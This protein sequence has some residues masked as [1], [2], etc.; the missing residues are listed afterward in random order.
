M[1]LYANFIG[2]DIAKLTFVISLYGAKTTREYENSSVGIAKFI[3]EHTHILKDSLCLLETTGG[4][5]LPLLYTLVDLGYSVHRANARKVKH[6]IK[7]FGNI[8]KTDVLDA[9]A[10]GTYAHER[11]DK[12]ELFK[13]HSKEDIRLFQLVQRRRD[14]NQMLISEKNRLQTPSISTVKSSVEQMINILKGELEQ[15]T[16]AIQS[17]ID[18]NE[19]LK[20]KQKVLKSVPGIGNIV[21]FELLIL[22]PELGTLCRRK[23]ASLAGLA[24]RANE[25]GKF[26]GYRRTSHGRVGVKRILFMAAMAARNSNSTLKIF[27]QRLIESGKKK[28][29]ALT[30]LMRKI[31]VI[32]NARLKSTL[33]A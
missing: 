25:S 18:S 8:A 33:Y 23:V 5:E 32:A 15:I 12:L 20:E 26:V 10:L 3:E 16:Q 14:I 2:I 29:V 6:F 1:S 7:S 22:L 11:K 31:L 21:A 4:Y 28:M 19:V 24:P 17:I 27:Y 30:A 13:P 9:K